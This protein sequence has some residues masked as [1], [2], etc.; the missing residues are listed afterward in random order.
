[1]MRLLEIVEQ[2]F[3]EESSAVDVKYQEPGKEIA[4]THSRQVPREAECGSGTN[5]GLGEQWRS[6]M[7]EGA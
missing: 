1:M 7:L 4:Q 5:V 6:L 3:N 2:R